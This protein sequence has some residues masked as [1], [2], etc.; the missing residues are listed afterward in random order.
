MSPGID[1]VALACRVIALL[2]LLLIVYPY[3]VYPL[4]LWGL[5]RI[6]GHTW[7]KGDFY[8]PISVIMAAH[9]EKSVIAQKLENT[10]ALEYPP[11]RLEIIVVSDCSTDGTNEIV[12]SYAPR[13]KL[14]PLFDRSG[15]QVAL[16]RA[17]EIAAGDI[18][19]FTDA[20]VN[21]SPKVAKY[22]T[23]NFLD[24]H[25][26][27]VS[28]VIKITK[29]G[30]DRFPVAEHDGPTDAEGAYLGFDIA[31]RA[32]EAQVYS[33][34]GCC[35][36]AYAVR[37]V[38]FEPFHP[39]DCNDFASALDAVRK[40]YRVVM[41]P[42]AVGYMLP[43]RTIEGEFRRK[44]RTIAGGL[45]TLAQVRH[46]PSIVGHSLF[47]WSLF[48][49]KVARWLGPVALVVLFPVALIGGLAGAW[50]LLILA[51]GIGGAFA[52]GYAAW[53]NE[54]LRRFRP[55]KM[56]AFAVVAVT[57]AL[58]GWQMYLTHDLPV[59]WAPTVRFD[60]GSKATTLPKDDSRSHSVAPG[61]ERTQA[62]IS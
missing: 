19:L 13:V 17:V 41:D 39:A 31:T 38:C 42:A 43:A 26:G 54:N 33:A 59:V 10:L 53:K 30:D 61:K 37:K 48:S 60:E 12:Q 24:P 45:W 27:A 6:I 55:L 47:W 62:T 15:K 7:S 20:S 35:G 36:S 32:L 5:R 50:E 52:A 4:L 25:V 29:E 49:H 40:G 18:L 44:A 46:W 56:A 23:R 58:R 9:N 11:D 8:P 14:L 22:L 28:T 34:V 21:L 2:L 51:I 1:D 57:A 3:L 16:N